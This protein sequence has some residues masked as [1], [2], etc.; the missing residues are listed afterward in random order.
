[1]PLTHMKQ[2]S[3]LKGIFNHFIMK[4]NVI[5]IQFMIIDIV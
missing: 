3:C 4:I 5:N 1:M 2:E